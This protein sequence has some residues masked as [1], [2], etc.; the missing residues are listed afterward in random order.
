MTNKENFVG[1]D[2]DEYVPILKDES[3]SFL[4][5]QCKKFQPKSILEIGTYIGY[6]S[7]VMLSC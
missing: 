2:K 4:F 1:I 7:S 6:S 3:I 5:E